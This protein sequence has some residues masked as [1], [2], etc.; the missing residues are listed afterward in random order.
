MGQYTH[1]KKIENPVSFPH[2][3]R[4]AFVL[5]YDLHLWGICNQHGSKQE[6]KDLASGCQVLG[7]L[8]WSPA[9]FLRPDSSLF[10]FG[11]GSRSSTP[12]FLLVLEP[13]YR[14]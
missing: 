1:A 13:S 10:P 3:T 4:L 9:S 2:D 14:I 7:V 5:I 8:I 6:V 11:P 12:L